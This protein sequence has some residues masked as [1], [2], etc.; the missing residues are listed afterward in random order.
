MSAYEEWA[1][2][3]EALRL[4]RTDLDSAISDVVLH[5]KKPVPMEWLRESWRGSS[6]Y[7]HKTVPRGEQHIEK[8][9]MGDSGMGGKHFMLAREGCRYSYEIVSRYHKFPGTNQRRG[10]IIADAL[11]V[12]RASSADHPLAVEIKVHHSNPWHAVV[13][14]LA[15]VRLLRANAGKVERAFRQDSASLRGGWGLALAPAA[16]WNK[17]HRSLSEAA[18]LLKRI[19]EVCDARVMIADSDQLA[20]GR[21]LW[22]AGYWPS[23]LPPKSAVGEN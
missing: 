8:V 18:S 4:R 11:A 5:W 6:G 23:E 13:E 22:R 9:F 3:W 1:D 14:N 21:I 20:Q 15:Q 10:Q 16:Y 17:H 12:L 2:R 7:R 19:A